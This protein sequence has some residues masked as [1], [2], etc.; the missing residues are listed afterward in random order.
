MIEYYKAADLVVS[1]AGEASVFLILQYS[2]N[3][4]IFVPRLKRYGEHVDDQQLMI[5]KYLKKH[6]LAH[7][8]FDISL[9]ENYLEKKKINR[10]KIDKHFSSQAQEL[11]R[12]IA[13]LDKTTSDL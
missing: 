6:K 12:L 13:N 1:A 5:G 2:R 10:S 9:L 7:V 11:R 3:I 8:V 4:P